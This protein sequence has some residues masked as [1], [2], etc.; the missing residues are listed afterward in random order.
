MARPCGNWAADM[1]SG[2]NS[3]GPGGFALLGV[4]AVAG[5]A[6]GVHGWSTRHMPAALGSIG[7]GAATTGARPGTSAA[8][9][10]SARPSGSPSS[11][12]ST[13]GPLLSSQ[14]YAQYAFQVWPGRLSPAARA[15]ETGLAITVRRQ[16][17]GLE[18]SAGVS[19]QPASAPQFYPAGARV[20]VIEASL[21]D[22]S[23]ASDYNLG[24]DGIVVTDARGRIVR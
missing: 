16:G 3:V 8:A 21:G 11:P 14:P 6:L 13:L 4:A 15:A 7:A 20:Y 2:G 18:V 1:R 22:D 10:P 19:G 17:S 24:D 12:V 23:G 9:G 5:I